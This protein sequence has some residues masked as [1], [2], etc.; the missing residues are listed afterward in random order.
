MIQVEPLPDEQWLVTVTARTTTKHR[1]RLNASD[2]RRFGG[3][4]TSEELLDA[5]FRFLLDRS[6]TRQSSA[7]S[8]SRSL[9][10]TSPITNGRSIKSLSGI[11]REINF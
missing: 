8:I 11:A 3:T 4:S 1:V 7:N 6:R 9:A 10:A 2:L 5:S